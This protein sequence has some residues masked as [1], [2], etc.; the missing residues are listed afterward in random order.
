METGRLHY[1]CVL[2]IIKVPAGKMCSGLTLM[3]IWCNWRKSSFIPLS[4]FYSYLSFVLIVKKN[5][6]TYKAKMPAFK[7]REAYIYQNRLVFSILDSFAFWVE[8]EKCLE[9]GVLIFFGS[10]CK[11]QG[12]IKAKINFGHNFWVEGPSNFRSTPLSNIFDSLFRDTPLGHVY[13]AHQI[14]K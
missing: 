13:C 3:W 11:I 7:L 12:K 1:I 9:N 10:Q 14:T 5:K 4:Y 2:F 6:Q 8:S